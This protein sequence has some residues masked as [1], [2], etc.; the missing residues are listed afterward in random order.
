[1]TLNIISSILL[2]YVLV[3]LAI[4]FYT[5]IERKFLGYFQLRKGPNKPGLIGL[6][7]PFADAIKLFIKEQ[8][9]PYASNRI[10]FILA[11][12][13]SLSLAL[14]IWT[15]FPHPFQS[16][17]IPFGILLFLCVSRINVYATFLA[18]WCSN[19]KYA[20]I[21]ALR[22]V[23][24]TVSYEVRISLIIICALL[25]IFTFDLTKINLNH[26]TPLYIIILPISILWFITNLAETNRTPF[27][28]AEG[29]SE[30]V[31][32]FNVEYSAGLFAL[33]FIA[34]YTSILGIRLLTATIFFSHYSLNIF[35]NTILLLFKTLILATL[36][37][38]LRATLP[39]IRYDNLIYLTW[40]KFLPAAL[41]SIIIIC[42]ILII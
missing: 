30:L 5:L 13:L 36:F 4:A 28:L 1:M 29:E 22:G 25:F 12:A 9:K 27:D 20:L 6:P 35:I 2:N 24:Q 40:K 15:L 42:A 41:A 39:R 26:F 7:Q 8:T 33:I 10:P 16:F 23:A 31:S 32:G 3:L 11:P 34:E 38:W 19:S 17:F 37:I 14:I 21:G 18:G